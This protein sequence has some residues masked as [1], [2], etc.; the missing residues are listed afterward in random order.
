MFFLPLKLLVVAVVLTQEVAALSPPIVCIDESGVYNVGDTVDR[1]DPCLMCHCDMSGE[2]LCAAYS[3]LYCPVDPTPVEGQCCGDCYIGDILIQPGL[4]CVKNNETYHFGDEIPSDDPCETCYCLEDTDTLCHMMY[5]AE[6]N[7]EW[8][9]KV[10]TCCGECLPATCENDGKIYHV[11]DDIDTGNP[12]EICSC[13]EGGRMICALMDCPSCELGSKYEPVEGQCCGKCS[14][15]DITVIPEK[16]CLKDGQL[17]PFH[18]F[19][20]SSN[21]CEFCSCDETGNTMCAWMDCA[22]CPEDMWSPVKGSCCGECH[23]CSW[24]N[25]TFKVGPFIDPNDKCNACECLENGKVVCKSIK[26]LKKPPCGKKRRA[27]VDDQ[28][29]QVCQCP[30]KRRLHMP[31]PVGN[32]CDGCICKND[33]KISCQ[34]PKCPNVKLMCAD[35]AV[36]DDCC[37][38]CPNGVTCMSQGTIIKPGEYKKVGSKIC[39]CGGEPWWSDAFCADEKIYQK[40]MKTYGKSLAHFPLP[41]V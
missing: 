22:P 25:A 16:G 20:K 38:Y 15:G 14:T 9:P 23:V 1:G 2:I 19:M 26:C 5:C 40:L 8:K 13:G 39:Y 36:G 12:C 31:G 28:C 37:P 3:C 4:G 7:G 18:G 6:C 34:A 24:S 41:V 33:G 10:G 27:S 30:Y 32:K 21:P 29:C 35:P 17:Y 11:G